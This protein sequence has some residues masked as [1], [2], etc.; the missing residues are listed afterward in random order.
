MSRMNHRPLLASFYQYLNIINTFTNFYKGCIIGIK[1]RLRVY[2]V[3][4]S[5]NLRNNRREIIRN[6]HRDSWLD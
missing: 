1:N 6:L 3:E 4:Q 2:R 5:N